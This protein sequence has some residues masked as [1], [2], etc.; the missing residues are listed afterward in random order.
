RTQIRMWEL[1]P[2]FSTLRALSRHPRIGSLSMVA[3]SVEEQ[4]VIARH[5]LQDSFDYR[6]LR[7]NLDELQP[8]FVSIEQLQRDSDLAFFNE[9]LVRELPGDESV[10]AYIFLGPD[11]Y[12]RKNREKE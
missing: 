10:D 1:M 11:V 12:V 5:G 6:A 8:A 2:R 4:T 7:T 3:Y 9:M